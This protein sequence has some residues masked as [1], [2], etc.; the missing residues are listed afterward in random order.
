MNT[1]SNTVHGPA[2]CGCAANQPPSRAAS[3]ARRVWQA[4][5]RHVDLPL[6]ASAVVLVLLLF[7]APLQ[8]GPSLRFTADAVVGILP[9]LV[10][11]VA[12]AAYARASGIDRLVAAAFTGH[13][14]R[15]I[16][17]AA[18]AGALSPFCSCGVIPVI[19]GLLAAGVPLAPVMAFWL[20]SPLMDPTM[21]ALTAAT[22]GPG[23]AV[24]KAV[25]AFGVG[26]LSGGVTQVL[27]THGR[28]GDALRIPAT[29]G[30]PTR[31]PV[32]WNV[33]GSAESRGVFFGNAGG[34]AWFLL[35]WMAFAFLLESL[36][37]AWL[38]ADRVLAL[39]GEEATAIPLAVLVGVPAYLNGFAALPLVS[40]LVGLGM[41]P[42]AALAFLVSGGIASVPAAAA[43]WALAQPRV[44]AL[45]LGLGIAGSLLA[46]YGYGL[47][48]AISS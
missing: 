7:E 47:V 6:G 25:A 35:R 27:S 42:A 40:G 22:L 41:S 19:A 33:L 13:P 45:Y 11:S 39:I 29:A 2:A 12:F 17:L 32:R 4:L 23:F 3:L 44:F 16:V 30:L 37:V 31:G 26:L 38:P 46:A 9:W 21:F 34:T 36:M 5:F 18:L 48:L 24:A 20:S 10:I 14:A 15:M 28:L 1:N 43:V 8:L